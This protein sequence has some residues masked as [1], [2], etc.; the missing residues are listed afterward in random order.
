MKGSQISAT[1][2]SAVVFIVCFWGFSKPPD[3]WHNFDPISGLF[4]GAL[5]AGIVWAIYL[6]VE[7]LKKRKEK[8]ESK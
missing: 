5:C 8:K 4:S 3:S 2:L 6:I 7:M 1:I